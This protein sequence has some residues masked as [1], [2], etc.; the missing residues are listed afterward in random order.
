M[1]EEH[2]LPLSGADDP[3]RVPGAVNLGVKASGIHL[4]AELRYRRLLVVGQTRNLDQTSQQ[5]DIAGV[6]RRGLRP[7]CRRDIRR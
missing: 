5:I 7:D 4:L 3:D 6:R 2:D 1:T